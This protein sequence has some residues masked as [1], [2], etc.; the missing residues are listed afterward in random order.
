L[1]RALST[2]AT[3][4]GAPEPPSNGNSPL[5]PYT[6]DPLGMMWPYMSAASG[7][8]ALEAADRTFQSHWRPLPLPQRADRLLAGAAYLKERREEVSKDISASTGKPL[9]QALLEVDMGCRK[10]KSAP[11]R[12]K[13][14][15]HPVP[16]HFY[17]APCPPITP[18]S[19]SAVL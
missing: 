8:A 4:E 18:T 9:K 13:R 14:A 11:L 17:P 19:R 3:L 16:H 6:G 12:S 15:T 1:A 7:L 10:I 2:E 5:N